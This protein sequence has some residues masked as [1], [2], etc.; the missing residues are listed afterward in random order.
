MKR[1]TTLAYFLLT[2]IL[3]SGCSPDNESLSNSFSFSND[4][5]YNVTYNYTVSDYP[6]YKNAEELITASDIVLTGKV[7]DIFFQMLDSTTGLPPTDQTEERNNELCTIYTV[8]VISTYKGDA[9]E[10]VNIRTQGGLKDEYLDQQ[11]LA[12]GERA[13]NG[14]TVAQDMPEIKIGET[15]LFSL[16]VFDGTDPCLMNPDQGI[17]KVSELSEAVVKDEYGYISAKD[18]ISYFG[19]EK[20]SAFKSINY[21]ETE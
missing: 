5:E 3:L 20:W 17:I 18:M 21:I 11:I 12:L 9:S 13:S 8:E 7:T 2:V 19:E 15:Y 10:A 4:S 16:R 1:K 6:V 14:I